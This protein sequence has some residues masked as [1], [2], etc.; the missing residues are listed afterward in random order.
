MKAVL[1]Y[2]A[3]PGFRRRIGAVKPDWLDITIVDEADETAFRLAMSDAEVLLHV[4]KPITAADI[5]ASPRLRFIQKIGVGVNTIDIEAARA[6][7]IKVANM[8]G[9]N[10]QAVAEMAL[11]LMLAALRRT[12]F[13][14]PATRAGRGWQAELATF[15]AIG[16]ISGRVVG[17]LGYGEVARRLAPV[18]L[19]LG[20]RV[21]YTATGPKPD[22]LA[23]WRSLA[24]L[25]AESD[26]ISLHLPLTPETANLIDAHAIAAMKPGAIL[27]NTSRGGLI[28][29]TALIAALRSGRLR[30]AGLDVFAVEPLAATSEILKLDNVVV[31]PHIAWLTPETLERSLVIAVEN[32]RRLYADD[33]LLHR[34]A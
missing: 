10:S 5:A 12:I 2:R 23:F 1:H 34:V 24:A 19:A 13:F 16:E 14:D 33:V 8:P 30:A 7:G 6:R 9:T 18:L 31:M 25:L 17:L 32:C 29:E 20:A 4:L 26:I 15:D 21:V 3:S 22:A 27:V 28:D 11:M